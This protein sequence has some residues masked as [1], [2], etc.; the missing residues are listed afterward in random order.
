MAHEVEQMFS[1]GIT[2]WHGLGNRLI[3]VPT[4]EEAIQKAGLDWRVSKQPVFLQNGGRCPANALV[5]ESDNSILGVV[6]LKYQPL[7]NIEAFKWFQPFIDS[8]MVSLE[9]AGS[10]KMGKKVWVLA[11]ITGNDISVGGDDDIRRYILLSNTHDGSQA[12]RIGFTPVR[13]VCANTMAYAHNSEASKL[14][15]VRHTSNAVLALSQIRDVMNTVNSSF[16]ATAEQYKYLASKSINSQ[17]LQNYVQIVMGYGDKKVEDLS[18]RAKNQIDNVVN[19]F[20]NGIGSDLK[21]ARGTYWGAYN[22]VTEL[23]THYTGKSADSRY[24][25]LWFGRN[26]QRNTQALE[27]AVKM[28]A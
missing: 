21:T 2:P 22:A 25:S 26:A 15:R 16:E 17:D 20:E 14:I 27:L 12:I 11:R 8:G 4:I 19:L 9:T 10:L 18:T 13:V 5:R 23:F 7:Q 3:E 6:G 1:V 28:A 24:D